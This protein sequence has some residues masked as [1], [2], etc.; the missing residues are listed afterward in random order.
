MASPIA[1]RWFV[2]RQSGVR[3]PSTGDKLQALAQQGEIKPDDFIRQG[4]DGRPIPASTVEGL[5]PSVPILSD[6][7][8]AKPTPPSSV[9]DKHRSMCHRLRSRLC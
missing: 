7:P 6:K 4:I 2:E 9:A 3:G 8:P 1:I 5:F